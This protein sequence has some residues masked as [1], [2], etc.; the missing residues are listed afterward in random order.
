MT[1]LTVLFNGMILLSAIADSSVGLWFSM[2][3]SVADT[4]ATS[5]Q[6]IVMGTTM[7][8]SILN[9][10]MPSPSR[11]PPPTVPPIIHNGVRYEQDLDS[12]L[13]GGTQAGGYLVAIDE[14]TENRLWMLRV[15]D[16]PDDASGVD[17]PGCYFRS[18]ILVPGHDELEID[19]EV[20][21]KYRVDLVER[22][23]TWISGPD[24]V[25]N[26]GIC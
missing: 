23:V 2:G 7:D 1:F 13:Y 6:A 19:N 8:E 18:M 16:I 4:Q 15:Y 17:V 12:R 5:K 26:S 20:G 10:G 9:D 21:G 22:S 11:P 14:A 24:S 25:Q 3:S